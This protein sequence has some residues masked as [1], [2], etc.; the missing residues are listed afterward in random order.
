MCMLQ[1]GVWR[2]VWHF[3][4]CGGNKNNMPALMEEF[5]KIAFNIFYSGR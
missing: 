5:F 3:L 2:Y 4:F 1:L